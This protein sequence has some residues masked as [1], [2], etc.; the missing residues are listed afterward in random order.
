MTKRSNAQRARQDKE[1]RE[2]GK[3][4]YAK[5]NPCYACGRSAGIN[6]FSHP[7]TDTVPWYDLALVLCKRC[8][9]LT[10]HMT[11]VEDF[12]KYKEQFGD[13]AYKAWKKLRGE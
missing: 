10:D 5:V 11:E 7:L 12:L 2:D 1:Y 4:R 8:A 9:N 6:Y 3:G 13:A